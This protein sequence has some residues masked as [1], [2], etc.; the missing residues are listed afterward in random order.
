MVQACVSQKEKLVIIRKKSKQTS[1]EKQKERKTK[2][3]T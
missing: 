1:K 2:I 3:F